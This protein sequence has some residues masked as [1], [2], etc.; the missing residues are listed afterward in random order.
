MQNAVL[1]A[2]KCVTIFSPCHLFL[3]ES[4]ENERWVRDHVMDFLESEEHGYKL[5]MHNRDFVP[6]NTILH[7]ICTSIKHS[8]RLISVVTR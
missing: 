8:R 5:C 7:N 2:E 3:F 6:G 1:A 4:V